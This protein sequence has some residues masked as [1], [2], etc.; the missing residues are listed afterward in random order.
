[1]CDN[2]LI[3]KNVIVQPENSSRVT[4]RLDRVTASVFLI[5]SQ[6]KLHYFISVCSLQINL[7]FQ[8]PMITLTI[9][10]LPW[11]DNLRFRFSVGFGMIFQFQQSSQRYYFDSFQT[12][13]Y[14]TLHLLGQACEN[15][16]HTG[17]FFFLIFVY[18][19]TV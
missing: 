8:G 12:F 2:E 6:C 3:Q 17:P 14:S 4:Q 11:W 5:M 13:I 9:M 7:I 1:M 10:V 19:V 16:K 15:I 18:L